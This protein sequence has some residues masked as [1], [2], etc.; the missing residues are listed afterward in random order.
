MNV[1]GAFE[2]RRQCSHNETFGAKDR[3]SIISLRNQSQ[4]FI[5]QILRFGEWFV[6]DIEP[7]DETFAVHQESPVKVA[8]TRSRRTPDIALKTS[9]SESETRGNGNPRPE[10]S[11]EKRSSDS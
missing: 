2:S 3:A 4:R 6:A 11:D 5:Q 8:S 7:A 10:S 9:H 1:A